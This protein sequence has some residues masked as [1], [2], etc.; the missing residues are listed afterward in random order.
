MRD[1]NRFLKRHKSGVW[2][3]RR[4]VPLNVRDLDK[5]FSIEASLKT[6]SLEV[7]RAR[8]DAMEEA[9]QLHW[10][11]LLGGGAGAVDPARAR[12][13]AALRGI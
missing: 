8:R 9:D 5:R 3:Y 4:R 13:E 12:Y 1:E 7:A 2:Y 6:K 10:S 11:A